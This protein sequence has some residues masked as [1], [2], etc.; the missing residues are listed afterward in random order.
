MVN[1]SWVKIEFDKYSEF[2]SLKT[3]YIYIY[4]NL[5]SFILMLEKSL[6]ILDIFKN[7]FFFVIP[8]IN[9]APDINWTFE[10]K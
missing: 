9:I 6:N 7:L 5:F 2:T 1:K 4:I 8:I 3:L 10:F